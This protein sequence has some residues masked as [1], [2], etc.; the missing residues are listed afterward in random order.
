M[1]NPARN[2]ITNLEVGGVT[3]K[4]VMAKEVNFHNGTYGGSTATA[5]YT[6]TAKIKSNGTVTLT[7][8]ATHNIAVG[9][10]VYV[11]IGDARYDGVHKVTAVTSTTLSFVYGTETQS[12]QTGLS[13]ANGVN[14]VVIT[15]KAKASNV[16][17]ITFNYN[18]GFFQNQWIV[19]NI[20]D[21]AFDGTFQ[22][23]GV[24]STTITY[25]FAGTDVSSTSASGTIY[26]L[27]ALNLSAANQFGITNANPN[28]SDTTDNEVLFGGRI[29][30]YLTG[31]N[32]LD[33]RLPDIFTD[34]IVVRYFGYSQRPGGGTFSPD[35]GVLFRDQS[36]NVLMIG[37]C[38]Y[39]TNNTYSICVHSNSSG[40]KTT[41]LRNSSSPL[42]LSGTEG[43]TNSNAWNITQNVLGI[44]EIALY[45]GSNGKTTHF[46]HS[47]IRANDYVPQVLADILIPSTYQIDFN[48]NIG[49]FGSQLYDEVYQNTWKLVI[50]NLT[51]QYL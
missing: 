47:F 22:I 11:N 21:A 25:T 31:L 40:T 36:G 48:L 13:V 26:G 42:L 5:T 50:D 33:S 44:H 20:S 6:V 19:I 4:S 29:A 2:H 23:S 3:A 46:V 38:N 8:S 37:G 51:I 28:A 10:V 1:A 34:S 17:T 14:R 41:L 30:Y 12:N 45:K 7:T 43:Y 16:V 15:N 24:T 27:Y 35:I 39:S 49:A 9:E 32:N 18:H